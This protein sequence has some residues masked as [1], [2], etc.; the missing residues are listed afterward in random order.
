[1]RSGAC[2]APP[3]YRDLE[4]RSRAS[5]AR[6]KRARGTAFERAAN[7]AAT[8]EKEASRARKAHGRRM[9]PPRVRPFN[10]VNEESIA[11][12][13][14]ALDGHP[15]YKLRKKRPRSSCAWEEK[16]HKR[17]VGQDAAISGCRRDQRTVRVSR[18]EGPSGS[19]IFLGRRGSRKE[20][21]RRRSTSS[22]SV[23]ETAM[24]SSNSEYM[25]KHTVSRRRI[26][27][28]LR[29]GTTK[30]PSS[31]RPGG[32]SPFSVVALRRDRESPPDVFT[33]L[34][35]S[36]T[37]ASPT[38]RV[39]PEAPHGRLQAHRVIM[40]S[41]PRTADCARPSRLREGRRRGDVTKRMRSRVP[42]SEGSL[43]PSS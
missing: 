34:R 27:S 17:V 23:D 40:T 38:L 29:R 4:T 32:A 10:E 43:S 31:P 33:G 8:R 12:V 21:P 5:G 25:E 2:R 13:A 6:G 22:C 28:R 26:A 16:L 19:F 42:R 41:K 7:L 24:C 11:D 37:G 36:R 20:R 30:R 3:D 39:A 9:A 18:I 14:R 15:V 1:V 35:S